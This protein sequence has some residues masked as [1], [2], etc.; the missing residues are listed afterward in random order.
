MAALQ[1]YRS[2]LRA[3]RLTFQ[4]D[5]RLLTNAR[6][7]IRAG[8]RKKAAL[9]PSDPAVAPAVEHARQVAAMLR[10]NVVQG[11]NE[12]D[13]RYSKFLDLGTV[14]G[15]RVMRIGILVMLTDMAQQSSGFTSI[16]KGATMIRSRQ[17]LGKP[18][19]LGALGAARAE[20]LLETSGQNQH[21]QSGGPLELPRWPTA[22]GSPRRRCADQISFD[23]HFPGQSQKGLRDKHGSHRM[24]EDV[25]EGD[26]WCKIR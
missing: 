13:G 6:E 26:F 12:G 17:P 16:P 1:A 23:I 7:Q 22:H 2:L 9:A 24:A 15:F 3:T 21:G 5:Q 18:S 19:R 4:G 10:E 11:R 20:A 8:F 25:Q 14:T